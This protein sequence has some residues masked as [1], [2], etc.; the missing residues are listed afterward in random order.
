MRQFNNKSML[1]LKGFDEFLEALEEAG[2]K[3]DIEGRKCFEKCAENLQDELVDKAEKAKI[4]EKLIDEISEEIIEKPYLWRYSVGWKKSKPKK[5]IL[6]DTYKV[7][8]MNYGT[9]RRKTKKGA[10]RGEI[11]SR[12][13]IKKAKLAAARKN[14][15]VMNETLNNILSGLE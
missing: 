11:K 14:K 9:P 1:Q 2:K 5:D 15:K 8:F 13:F 10:N 6:P 12:R 3:C 7:M 4:P